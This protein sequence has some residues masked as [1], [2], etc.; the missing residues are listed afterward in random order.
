MTC[1]KQWYWRN[2]QP[3]PVLQNST[4]LKKGKQPQSNF[5]SNKVP[6]NKGHIPLTLDLDLFCAK[7]T[8]LET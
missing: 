2:N 8:T 7:A 4:G 1:G 3:M 6:L 5:H